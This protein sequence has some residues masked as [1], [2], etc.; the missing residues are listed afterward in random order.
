MKR[1]F[2]ITPVKGKKNKVEITFQK[3][4]TIRVDKKDKLFIQFLMMVLH[5]SGGV[6]EYFAPLLG[7]TKS[8]FYNLERK[9]KAYGIKS[10]LQPDVQTQKEKELTEPD[11]GK[12]IELIVKNP[13]DTNEEIAEKFNVRST[14]HIDFKSVEKI[15]NQFGLKTT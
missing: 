8:S 6:A 3:D 13:N 11:I 1:R 2:S 10:L 12:I 15:R 5:Y 4:F 14:S 9:V 7:F